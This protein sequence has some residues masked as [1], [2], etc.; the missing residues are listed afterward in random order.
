MT[1]KSY[2]QLVAD[3]E[4]KGSVATYSMAVLRDIEGAG[5]L[6]T[7]VRKAISQQL[8]AH[9]LDHLPEDLPTYQEQSVRIFKRGTRV[10]RVIE[11]VLRPSDVG[12]SVLR[13]IQNDDAREKIE[14]IERILAS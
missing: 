12:D 9:G 14:Q 11:A 3:V 8:R 5:K 13:S 1:P 7:H 4:A 10:H 2:D 6:G